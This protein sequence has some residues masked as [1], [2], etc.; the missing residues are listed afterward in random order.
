[1]GTKCDGRHD[2]L[3]PLVLRYL[4]ARLGRYGSGGSDHCRG[5]GDARLGGVLEDVNWEG[6]EELV[7]EDEGGRRFFC[8]V[9][10]DVL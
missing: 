5:G 9:W 7:G 3:V 4:W 10:L 2:E 8:V 1:M 6:I